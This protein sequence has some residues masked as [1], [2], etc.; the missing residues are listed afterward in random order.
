[1]AKSKKGSTK[2]KKKEESSDIRGIVRIAGK[3][4]KGHFPMFKALS[5][6]KGVGRR[7]ASIVSAIAARELG[8]TVDAPIG[9]FSDEQLERMEEIITNP[10]K[11]NVPTYLLN[12]RREFSSGKD[13]HLISNDLIFSIRQD[14]EKEMKTRSW[15]GISHMFRKKVRGQRTRTSGRRGGTLGV[16]RKKNQ[17]GKK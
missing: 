1:M 2:S 16:V 15:R 9:S 13:L 7:Y 3:D 14:I 4:V 5:H 11:Y 10:L 17:P 6:V 8:S 12:K